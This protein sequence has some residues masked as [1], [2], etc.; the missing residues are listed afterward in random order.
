MASKY[1]R[2]NL[3][4]ALFTATSATCVTGLTVVDT[5]QQFTLFGQLVILLLLQVGGLGIMTFSIFFTVLMGKRMSMADKLVMQDTLQYFELDNIGRLIKRILLVTL[6]IEVLGA[7]PLFLRWRAGMGAEKAFY[8]AIFHSVSA[9]C[10][11]GF[12]L[13]PKGMEPFQHDIIINLGM[14]SLITL[15]GLGF[16]VL[17]DMT[18]FFMLKLK[19][20]SCRLSLQSKVVLS[21]SLGLI[22]TGTLLIW[23]LELNNPATDGTFLSCLFQSVTARTAGFNT[24]PIGALSTTSLI[25]IIILMY[26]GASPGSTGGGIKTT[27]FTIFVATL[28]SMVYDR[29]QVHLFHRTIPRKSIH[30]VAAIIGLSA[31]L[32][33]MATIALILT[34]KNQA[35][36][37]QKGYPLRILF[38]VVSAFGTVGLSTGITPMLSKLARFFVTLIMFIGRIGPLTLALALGRIKTPPSYKYPEGRITVG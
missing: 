5:G 7:I 26:I 13:F 32:I 14:I 2:L 25:I 31:F 37:A 19:K 20:K 15:G 23:L 22:I 18:R 28:R 12:S 38:E 35:F 36:G 8:Y 29:E 24:L 16:V 21:T 10:N 11:A 30:K 3:V 6:S 17:M 1:Q 34:E 27:S 4:D 9:F 33:I